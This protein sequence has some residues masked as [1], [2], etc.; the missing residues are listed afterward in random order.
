MEPGIYPDLPNED[1]HSGPGVSSTTLKKMKKSAAHCRVHMLA[2]HKA[3]RA[4]MIGQAVHEAVLEPALFSDHYYVAPSIEDYPSALVSLADYQAVAKR[5]DLKTTGTKAALKS[6]IKEVA[7]DTPFWDDLSAPVEGKELLPPA[8]W[9]VCQGIQAAIHNNER[10]HRMLSGGVAE[11]SLFWHDDWTNELCKARFDYYRQDIGIIA[12]LKTCED[13][14]Y[15]EA[16]RA[17]IK[18]QY[19][20]SAAMYLEAARHNGL[21]AKG[22]AWVFVEKHA[23]YEIGLY[24]ASQAML[25]SGYQTYRRYLDTYSECCESGIWPGYTNTFCEIDL[26]Y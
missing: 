6:A 19:H 4:L 23:P 3:T 14:T 25:D 8:D 18:Y 15:R 26:P 5:L 2:N 13:A 7:P 17:I 10:A 12:D 9:K 24:V 11:T 22:F 1:Y 21:P 20:V 16:Q